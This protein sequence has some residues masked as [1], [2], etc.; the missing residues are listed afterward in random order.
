MGKEKTKGIYAWHPSKDSDKDVSNLDHSERYR[1]LVGGVSSEEVLQ[2]RV[3]WSVH[4]CMRA[5]V[6]ACVCVCRPMSLLLT[7]DVSLTLCLVQDT[8]ISLKLDYVCLLLAS[9]GL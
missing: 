2:H 6:R 9:T 4:V 1:Q 3:L 8:S 5:C 7:E